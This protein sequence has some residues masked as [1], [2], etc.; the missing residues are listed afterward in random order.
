MPLKPRRTAFRASFTVWMPLR[1]IGPFQAWRIAGS[2]AQ[3]LP[4][5]GGDSTRWVHPESRA[6]CS[7]AA[8]GLPPPGQS[9][10]NHREAPGPAAAT[11]STD[12]L[13]CIE[14]TYVSPRAA[15]RSEEHT[16]ELQSRQYLVCRLLLE[17]K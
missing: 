15:A 3:P 17:K 2:A 14:W 10:A 13:A 7:S 5:C 12:L 8:S 16:S 11:S 4:G 6:R 9:R 1:T